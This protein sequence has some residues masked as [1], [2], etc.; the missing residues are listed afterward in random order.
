[1]KTIKIHLN[2]FQTPFFKCI[3][4]ENHCKT[5]SFY[6]FIDRVSTLISSFSFNTFSYFQKIDFLFIIVCLWRSPVYFV[7]MYLIRVLCSKKKLL[8]FCYSCEIA[9]LE[10]GNRGW[11]PNTLQSLAHISCCRIV[12]V[13]EDNFKHGLKGIYNEQ[14]VQNFR[15]GRRIISICLVK[16]CLFAGEIVRH[17]SANFLL[18][19]T[20]VKKKLIL[21]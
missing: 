13:R 18:F 6:E 1:M 17:V 21:N 12:P 11:S 8:P 16:F 14:T 7:F 20:K 5:L 15:K 10:T 2:Y 3:Y 19:L 4:L 9:V